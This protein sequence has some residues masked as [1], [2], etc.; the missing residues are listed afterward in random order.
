[1]FSVN[2]I[3]GSVQW[4][5]VLDLLRTDGPLWTG[6]VLSPIPA[7][8]IG[9]TAKNPNRLNQPVVSYDSVSVPCSGVVCAMPSYIHR[10]LEN[11]SST[12]RR[13]C[14]DLI[15]DNRT[16]CMKSISTS[17]SIIC[18]R[19]VNRG[20]CDWDD[21]WDDPVDQQLEWIIS[22]GS[23][24]INEFSF[25]SITSVSSYLCIALWVALCFIFLWIIICRVVHSWLKHQ[26][27]KS[28]Y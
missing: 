22:V 4:L 19:L 26:C 11:T 1:M 14:D 15:Q 18:N 6:N 8:G 23:V 27:F 13:I 3:N 12:A 21:L 20:Y 5:D 16:L 24:S 25:L 7:W 28:F 17:R 10:S 9:G 2:S